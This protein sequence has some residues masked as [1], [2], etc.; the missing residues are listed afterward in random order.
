MKN[1]E[2]YYIY[3]YLPDSRGVKL[4]NLSNEDE[5]Y[6]EKHDVWAFFEPGGY[7]DYKLVF[8]NQRLYKVIY[9]YRPVELP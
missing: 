6:L 5:K 3:D 1:N 4:L 8:K 9:N 7:S 2:G